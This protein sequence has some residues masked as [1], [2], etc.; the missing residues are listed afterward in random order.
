MKQTS[1][2]VLDDKDLEFVEALRNLKVARSVASLIVFLAR[3]KK[4]SSR[5]IEM[6]TNLRQPEVSIGM[7][8]LRKNNWIEEQYL[9]KEG[10]GRPMIVYKLRVPLE[11]IIKHFEEESNRKSA[12]AMESIQRLKTLTTT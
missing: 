7:R 4:A 1:I 6:G 9:K 11:T 5:E 10:I 3:S 12:R 2:R 8:M